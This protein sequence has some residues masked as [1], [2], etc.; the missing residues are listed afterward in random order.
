[1]IFI[2]G[3]L[4]WYHNT[5]IFDILIGGS[6]KNV[7]M[8]TM[9]TLLYM[10][11]SRW[12]MR[13]V[14]V[15]V[16]LSCILG[17]DGVFSPTTINGN[18]VSVRVSSITNLKVTPLSAHLKWLTSLLCCFQ[19]TH[20]HTQQSSMKSHSPNIFPL[21]QTSWVTVDSRTPDTLLSQLFTEQEER[22]PPFLN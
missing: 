4:S 14:M 10:W 1:M 18:G 12:Q 13:C 2:T 22:L 11:T 5:S 17:T 20:T 6:I 7:Y 15:V 16:M 9:F 19:L 3:L 8:F 21:I